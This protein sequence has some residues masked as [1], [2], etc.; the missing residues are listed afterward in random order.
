MGGQKRMRQI[1]VLSLFPLAGCRDFRSNYWIGQGDVHRGAGKHK[2]AAAAY[3]KATAIDPTSGKAWLRLG[4]EYLQTWE[5]DLAVS[6]LEQATRYDERSYEAWYNLALAR[7]RSANADGAAAALDRATAIDP[8][9]G[10]GWLLLC[11]VRGGKGE[12][13]DALGAC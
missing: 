5:S 2:E 1:A 8:K 7:L 4:N 9:I 10:D 6:A 11:S 13:L 12:S 3:A